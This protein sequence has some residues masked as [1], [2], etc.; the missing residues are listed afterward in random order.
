MCF[1]LAVLKTYLV[2]THNLDVAICL[3]STTAMLCLI[4]KT[5]ASALVLLVRC[6]MLN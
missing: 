5:R 4:L 3:F 6:D 1:Y 2:G